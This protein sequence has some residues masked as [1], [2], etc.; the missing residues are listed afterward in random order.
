MDVPPEV[1]EYMAELGRRGGQANKGKPERSEI[2]RK[3]VQARWA[4]HRAK[5][6]AE[7]EGGKSK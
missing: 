4:K 3:A 6:K 2:C 7:V 5:K 1:R